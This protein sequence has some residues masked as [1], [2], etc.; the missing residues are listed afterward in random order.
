M[1]TTQAQQPAP[2]SPSYY[3]HSP[4][5]P[6]CSSSSTCEPVAATSALA[7]RGSESPG[8]LLHQRV[9]VPPTPTHAPLQSR[10]AGQPVSLDAAAC[11]LS[12]PRPQGDPAAEQARLCSGL[13]CVSLAEPEQL[14]GSTWGARSRPPRPAGLASRAANSNPDGSSAHPTRADSE[15]SERPS[16]R[17]R[18]DKPVAHVDLIAWIYDRRALHL[19]GVRERRVQIG[20]FSGVDEDG[21][22]CGF[23]VYNTAYTYSILYTDVLLYTVLCT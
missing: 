15:L 13:E 12:L 1:S 14:Q 19:R 4:R 20:L 16:N 23:V 5:Q 2:P 21:D 3:T 11:T 8:A 6:P 7:A 22:T 17:Q 18:G 9:P 10:F